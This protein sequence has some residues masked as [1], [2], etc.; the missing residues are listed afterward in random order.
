MLALEELKD[1]NV[2]R[3]V[4]CRRTLTKVR[5]GTAC[6]GQT[7]FEDDFSTLKEDVWQIEH[8]IPISSHP[9]HPFVSY[10]NRLDD[11]VVFVSNGFLQIT[12]K[13]LE[14]LSEYDND[15][16]YFEDLDLNSQSGCTSRAE[17]CYRKASGADILPPVVSGR[18]TSARFAFTYGIVHIR[19]KLPQGDWLYP[20]LLLEPFL[21]KYG[22]TDYASGVIKIATARGNKELKVGSEKYGNDVLYGG[23]VM[24]TQC[25]Q[26]LLGKKVHEYGLWGD[27]FHNYTLTWT[28]YH[29]SLAIDGE[30]WA[31]IKAGNGL[32]TRF[33]KT[34]TSLLRMK[35][36]KGTPM[37]PYDDSFY[38]TLGLAVGGITEFPDD[39]VTGGERMKPWRNSGRKGMLNF[40]QDVSAWEKTWS[41]PQLLVALIFGIN[42]AY[43]RQELLNIT[44]NDIENQGKMLLVKIPNTKNK[45][46]RSFII[47][48]PFYDVVKKYEA[49]RTTKAKNNHFFQ[50]YQKG[51]CTAQPI[52]INKNGAMPKEV[53]KFLGLPDADCYTGYSFRRTSATLLADSGADILTL[54]RHG[55]WRSNAVAESYVEDSIQNKANKSAKITLAINLK[56]QTKKFCPEP[57]PST[58]TDNTYFFIYN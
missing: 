24:N 11:P 8:Y 51:K 45:I 46:P 14:R 21:K 38:I 1:R 31:Q 32:H 25:R 4:K 58:S 19:A 17:E 9:E 48:G 53:S 47:D 6:G 30:E 27:D 34:C 36:Q 35:L 7:I 29:I 15:T 54:Q 50:N 12:A 18:V 52:G 44:T 3:P 5:G 37:A 55:G 28:P 41:Q 57:R 13:V 33:S 2:G 39:S 10:Q 16:V 43:R 56:L 40:W 49:L 26:Q 23:P 22:S 20:E 42:D